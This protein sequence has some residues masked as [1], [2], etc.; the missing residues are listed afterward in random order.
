MPGTLKSPEMAK[1]AKASNP[2]LVV[3]FTSGYTENS[4]VHGGK[5][6]PGVEL[7]SKPY[8]REALDGRIRHL[9]A[10]HS[11]LSQ[12][13]AA[14]SSAQATATPVGDAAPVASTS[15]PRKLKVLLV[16]DEA[17]IRINTADILTDMGHE[18]IEAGTAAE[19][20][21]AA[22]AQDFDIL[23][24]DV[25]LPDMKGG[26]LAH[27]VRALKPGRWHCLCHRREP[28]PRGRRRRRGT[29]DQTLFRRVAESGAGEI[30]IGTMT[31]TCT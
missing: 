15:E 13:A 30:P 16:E 24:T 25:G 26:E 14:P 7:L 19:A 11:Q 3:L 8:T 2:D 31:E 9:L 18:V 22:S 23:V 4:I 12:A 27:K 29:A 1:L 17:L 20:L 5:L 10:N 6:D 21:E 28:A